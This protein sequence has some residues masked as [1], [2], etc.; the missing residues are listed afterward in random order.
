VGGGLARD[1]ASGLIALKPLDVRP[2]N[3]NVKRSVTVFASLSLLLVDPALALATVKGPGE[4]EPLNLPSPDTA[5]ELGAAGSSGGSLT[6]T[7]LGLAVVVAVIYGLY[8][9]LKQVK[10][11]REERAHGQGLTVAATVPLGPNR[12]LHLVRAGRELVL[13]GTAEQGVVPIRTY[14]EEEAIE[15]GITPPEPPAGASRTD[16]PDTPSPLVALQGRTRELLDGLR[17]KTVRGG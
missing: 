6:R 15:L 10:K 5:Q 3:R 12:S 14:T 13:V 7:F 17:S 1:S 4:D 2:T 8:W 9:V 11:S 16:D